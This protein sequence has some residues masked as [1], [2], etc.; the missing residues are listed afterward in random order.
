MF[1]TALHY[2]EW[3]RCAGPKAKWRL[4]R[5][6]ADSRGYNRMSIASHV[7]VMDNW[8][9]DSRERFVPGE[10]LCGLYFKDKETGVEGTF[11]KCM[12]SLEMRAMH[13]ASAFDEGWFIE[14]VH[15]HESKKGKVK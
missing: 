10:T 6:A 4:A 14:P 2:D 11:S 7:R 13:L 9:G 8:L 15:E 3:T 1:T 12:L 5:M